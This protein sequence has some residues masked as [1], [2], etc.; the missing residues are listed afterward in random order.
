ME[1]KITS[2]LLGRGGQSEVY[3][4]TFGDRQVAVKRFTK[5]CVAYD[6]RGEASLRRLNHPNLIE[7]LGTKQDRHFV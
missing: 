5:E 2:I 1:I 3:Q 6:D 4:G 7:L